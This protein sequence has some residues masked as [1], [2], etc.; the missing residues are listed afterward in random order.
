MTGASVPDLGLDQLSDLQLG[1]SEIPIIGKVPMSQ[2]DNSESEMSVGVLDASLIC[3]QHHA[4]YGMSQI[5]VFIPETGEDILIGMAL[6]AYYDLNLSA[7]RLILL[8]PNEERWAVLASQGAASVVDQATLTARVAK[9]EMRFPPNVIRTKNTPP[10]PK[11]PEPYKRPPGPTPT[12][13][14]PGAFQA[15]KPP[16]GPKPPR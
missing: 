15:P 14:A 4:R 7:G 11:R 9:C 16:V 3:Q 2:A 10:E 6:L 8:R 12:P 5:P 13:A 1:L